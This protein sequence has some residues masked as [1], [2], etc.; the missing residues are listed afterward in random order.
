MKV[1]SDDE[2]HLRRGV[3]ASRAAGHAKDRVCEHDDCDDRAVAVVVVVMDADIVTVE[4]PFDL[5]KMPD[6]GMLTKTA[7]L[8]AQTQRAY[9]WC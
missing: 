5:H 9:C 1:R 8:W 3:A 4:K 7:P 6:E 2:G